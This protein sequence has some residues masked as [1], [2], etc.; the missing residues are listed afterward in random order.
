[1]PSPLAGFVAVEARNELETR[2]CWTTKCTLFRLDG[3]TRLNTLKIRP[4]TFQYCKRKEWN[5]V[6]IGG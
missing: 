5:P 3:K 4:Y 1:M 6:T 2:Y